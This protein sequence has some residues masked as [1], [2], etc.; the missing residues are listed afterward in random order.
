MRGAEKQ[1]LAEG[2]KM[3]TW[4]FG[5]LANKLDFTALDTSYPFVLALSQV[6]T[7]AILE[8]RAR[9]L[10]A[11]IL[12][13]HTV[14]GLTQ[15]DSSVTVE[16]ADGA[17]FS[18]QYVVGADGAGSTVRRAAGIGFPGTDA[19]VFG[20]LGDVVL[21]DTPPVGFRVH[22]EHGALM[23]APIPCGFVRVSGYDATDQEPGR[24]SVTMDEL[25]A[26]AMR[27]AGTDFGMRDPR[28]LSRFGNATRHAATY[29]KGRVLLAGDAAHIHFPAGGVGLNTGVQDAMN[30][31]WK[32]AAQI[33]GR[34][35]AGLL[36]SYHDERHPLGADVAEHTLA[37]TA[38][39]TA[40]STTG[41]ALRSLFGKL[42][43]QPCLAL[44]LASKLAALDVSYPPAA[45]GHPLVGTR[46]TG[47]E[48]H[49][50]AG[51]AIVLNMSGT[52]LTVPREY[53]IDTIAGTLADATA[54]IVRPDGYVWWATD[55]SDVDTVTRTALA[56]L[57]TTF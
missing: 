32:L 12:R 24:R 52:P 50:H 2:I 17:T 47:V 9:G 36:D 42:L 18:G 19:T 1:F 15:D 10:G 22:N 37:Q 4:H 55:E 49:L 20:Y 51:R 45:P 3:P 21:D 7:E 5:L 33:Q 41:R 30:L 26:T 43:T 11:E 29:R 6:R 31:G 53:G 25:R 14:T 56:E 34:A 38:L 57:G 23:T 35:A 54:A 44:P 16:L 28:W 27:I 8:E 40:T 48:Q 39:I 46:V 13:G